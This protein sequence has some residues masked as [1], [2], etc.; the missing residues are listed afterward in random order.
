MKKRAGGYKIVHITRNNA[1]VIFQLMDG[2]VRLYGD[3]NKCCFTYTLFLLL[4]VRVGV[5]SQKTCAVTDDSPVAKSCKHCNEKS[6]TK[7]MR[8]HTQYTAIKVVLLRAS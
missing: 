2:R 1:C 6:L 4:V 5:V 7:R 8:Q 3:C